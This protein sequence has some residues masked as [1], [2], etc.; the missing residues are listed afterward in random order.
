MV[1]HDVGKNIFGF[2]FYDGIIHNIAVLYAEKNLIFLTC[3]LD[4]HSC[5]FEVIVKLYFTIYESQFD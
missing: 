2:K 3:G 5:Q 4:W 1:N